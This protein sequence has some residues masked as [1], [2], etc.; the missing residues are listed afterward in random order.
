VPEDTRRLKP[1]LPTKET[2]ETMTTKETLAGI[3]DAWK[4]S[5]F[6]NGVELQYAEKLIHELKKQKREHWVS[7]GREK[8]SDVI[9]SDSGKTRE[10]AELYWTRPGR[11]LLGS[12]RIEWEE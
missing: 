10:S 3:L 11:M 7:I 12:A 6:F 5:G 9:T 1:L 4:I 8:D 2:K